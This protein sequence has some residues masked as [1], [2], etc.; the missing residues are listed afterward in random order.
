[1]VPDNVI[2]HH[3]DEDFVHVM[4]YLNHDWFGF[5]DNNEVGLVHYACESTSAWAV[6]SDGIR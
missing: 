2:A 6:S 3:G 5:N 1:M 4:R